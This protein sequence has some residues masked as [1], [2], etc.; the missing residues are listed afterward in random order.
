MFLYHA[1]QQRD[2]EQ[3]EP[4]Q[5]SVRDPEEGAVVFATPDKGYASMF[6]VRASDSWTRRGKFDRDG[7]WH[8]IISDQQRFRE[9]DEGGTLYRLPSSSFISDPGKNM[10]KTEWVS[11]ESVRP[12]DGEQYDS[13]L[14]AMLDNGVNVYFVD[15]AT[16]DAIRQSEDHGHEV[17]QGLTPYQK[18][19]STSSG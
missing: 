3:F 2:I 5:E 11:R 9:R 16:F 19:P 17:L 12:I 10:S 4:R 6:L 15:Q 18:D 7:P 13:G 1:S 14:Q 8:M